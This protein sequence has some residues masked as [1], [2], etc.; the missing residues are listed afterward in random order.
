MQEK[1]NLGAACPD[2]ESTEC[3]SASSQTA[4]QFS[5]KNSDFKKAFLRGDYLRLFTSYEPGSRMSVGVMMLALNR[6]R[7]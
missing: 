7:G 4:G 5:A 3:I 2:V 6:K 1:N